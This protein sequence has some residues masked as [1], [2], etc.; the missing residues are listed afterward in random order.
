MKDTKKKI[1][2]WKCPE[3]ESTHFKDDFIRAETY[4]QTCGLLVRGMNQVG[5]IYP[6][7]V[8]VYEKKQE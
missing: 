6:D 7:R 8:P 3:C 5:I 4:C 2:A 1:I